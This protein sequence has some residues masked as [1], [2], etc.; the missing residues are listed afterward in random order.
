M[1]KSELIEISKKIHNEKYEYTFLPDTFKTSDYVSFSYLGLIF[2]QRVSEHIKGL[3][4]EKTRIRNTDDFINKSKLLWGHNKYDYSLSDFTGI[5]KKIKIIY[6]KKIYEQIALNHLSGFKCENCWDTEKFIIE[7]NKIFKNRYD[8]SL[9]DYVNFKTPVKIIYEGSIYE[10]KPEHHLRGNRPENS[11]YSRKLDKEKFIKKSIEIFGNKYDYSLVDYVN[12]RTPVKIIFDGIVYEQRPQYHLSG[13]CPEGI[14]VI[15]TESFIAKSK[16]IFKNRYDYSLVEYKNKDE[17]VKILYNGQ[18]YL[19]RPY[20]HLRGDKPEKRNRKKTTEEFIAISNIIHGFKYS[21]DK[22]KYKDSSS[23]VI[24]TCPL[25][26][27]FEQISNSHLQGHGCS[28]CNES[29]GEKI[30]SKF[31]DK[32]KNNYSRQKK[33]IDCRN[34]FELPFDFY[35]PSKR[36]LIEFDGIQHFQ[37]V[38]Y[39]GGVSAYNILNENDKI[40]NDYCEENYINLIRIRYDQIDKIEEILKN[41]LV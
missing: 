5:R 11:D 28:L 2:K 36:T 29:K 38:E 37:P 32:N 14:N 22:L 7:S 16:K 20:Y 4:P 24:I 6:K 41:N 15:D 13:L 27:D 1:I 30:I 18:M 8:Y 33:F 34:V 17:Y 25:H 12:A 10:Q 40:K 35:I 26:G 31:L 23:K 39:F 3:P 19:Q 21:Y 9:T